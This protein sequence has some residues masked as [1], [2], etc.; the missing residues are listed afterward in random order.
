VRDTNG[1]QIRGITKYTNDAAGSNDAYYYPNATTLSNNRALLSWSHGGDYGDIFYAVIDSAGNTVKVSTNLSND[2]SSQWDWLSDAAQLADGRTV[3]AWIGNNYPAYRVRYAVLDASYNRVS[4]PTLLDNPA[5]LTGDAYVSVAA[6]GNN[7]ALTWLDYNSAYRRNL[8]YALI[9]SDGTQ[10]TPP[11]IFRTSQASSPYLETSYNGYGNTSFLSPSIT[12]I[13]INQALGQQLNGARKFVAGKD[14]AIR[15]FLSLPVSTNRDAQRV[16]VKR[17]GNTITTLYPQPAGG[18]T[19]TL[20]FQCPSR[21]ACGNWQHGNYTFEATVNGATGQTSATFEA[22]KTLRILAVPVKV[23]DEAVVKQLPDEQWK[24]AGQFLRQVYPIASDGL[25]WEIGSELDATGYDLTQD[26]PC[27]LGGLVGSGPCQLWRDLKNRQPFLCG[28]PLRPACYDKIIGFIPPMKTVCTTSCAGKCGCML[29]WTYGEK[30]AAVVVMA[31]GSF[32]SPCPE[33]PVYEIDDMRGV[34]AHEVGHTYGLGDEYD[35]PYGQYKC[36]INPPPP[37]YH[38]TPWGGTPSCNTTFTCSQSTEEPW[39][40]ALNTGSGSLMRASTYRPFETLPTLPNMQARGGLNDVLSLMG[41]GKYQRDLWVTP[42]IYDHLF[43]GLAPSVVARFPA[44]LSE[45]VVL[46]S[47][48]IGTNDAVTVEPWTHFTTTLTASMTGTYVIEAVD[49]LSQTL[50]SQGFEVSF[51]SLSN[52]PQVI[53]PAP[54]ETVVGFPDATQ[55]FRI[56]RGSTILQVV[57]VSTNAPVISVTAPVSGEMI[58]GIYTISWQSDDLDGG[59]LYH[60]VEFSRNGSDWNVLVATITETHFVANFD[61]LPGGNQAMIRVTTSDGVNTTQASSSPFVVS[62][63]PPEVFIMTPISG[64][65]YIAGATVALNGSAY[66]LQD[67]WLQSSAELVWS[68]DLDGEIGN[69]EVLNIQDLSSGQHI[70]TLSATNS[71]GLTAAGQVV[72]TVGPR[73]FLPLIAKN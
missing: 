15:V 48:W 40:S 34:V 59:G 56:R 70:I 52:P 20:T 22:R 5:A 46:A 64:T 14:T 26:G 66:D 67:G 50:A 37:N 13:E 62:T 44:N 49:S 39:P 29:G 55:A 58:S 51:I 43:D 16:V 17:D 28:M 42:R 11:Q 27:V 9:K 41:S 71:H 72:I 7:A 30:S 35:H 53:D 4:G 1:A 69:G 61:A 23:K 63:K 10:L 31:N 33:H 57:P 25:T 45:R 36:D 24:T 73:V 6:A 32:S 68:S 21:P 12:G 18:S 54:F 65:R 19:S 47:G 2:S 60:T 38:G 8:Y 3:V